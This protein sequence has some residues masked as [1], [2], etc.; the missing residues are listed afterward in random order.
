[1]AIAA[2]GRTSSQ[3]M[4]STFTATPVAS[5]NFF[6]F[7]FQASSSALMKPL[8]RKRRSCASFSIGSDGVYLAAGACAKE[9]AAAPA[10][11]PKLHFK[12]ERRSVM[13]CLRWGGD[14]AAR[15]IEMSK[16][17]AA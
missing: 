1:A 7:A 4:Y 8:H 5:W 14:S 3:V 10:A 16:R 2:L 11:T 12:N 9:R 17:R 6:E 13:S 15:E